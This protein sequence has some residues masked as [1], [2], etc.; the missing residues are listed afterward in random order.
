MGLAHRRFHLPAYAALA[1][2][3]AFLAFVVWVGIWGWRTVR[4]HLLAYAAL[5]MVSA[6]L[7]ATCR[8][9]PDTTPQHEQ[10]HTY[11]THIHYLVCGRP[12]FRALTCSAVVPLV[13]V[14]SLCV[15]AV[16]AHRQTVGSTPV[17]C[18]RV[19]GVDIPCCIYVA[20]D[21]TG[22]VGGEMQPARPKSTSARRWRNA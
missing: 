2:A 14:A 11:N 17:E 19:S 13:V 8:R 20:Y 15:P 16:P 22:R 1:M 21:I 18:V 4:F 3:S 6:S 10:G 9:Q 12:H 7:S 5:A